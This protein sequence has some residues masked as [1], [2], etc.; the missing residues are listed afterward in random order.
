MAFAMPQ[1]MAT[2]DRRCSLGGSTRPEDVCRHAVLD[3]D[4]LPST[5][6]SAPVLRHSG[7]TAAR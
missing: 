2:S 4:R 7:L 1:T 3:G 6:L 5:D